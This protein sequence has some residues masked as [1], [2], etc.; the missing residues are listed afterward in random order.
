MEEVVGDGALLVPPSSPPQLAEALSSILEDAG[1]TEARRRRGLEI[2]SRYTWAA[3]AEAHVEVYREAV[4]T[5][6]P[7]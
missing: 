5:L 7:R 3:S 1:D 6:A 4:G 2:A